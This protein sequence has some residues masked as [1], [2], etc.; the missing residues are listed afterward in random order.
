M[1]DMFH[2][3]LSVKLEVRLIDQNRSLGGATGDQQQVFCRYSRAG[4]IIRIS[5]GNQARLW[6]GCVGQ[7]FGCR[8]TKIFVCRNWNDL[9]SGRG[10]TDFVHRKGGNHNQRPVIRLQVGLA[11]QVNS[12]V[13]AVGQ[14]H[15]LRLQSKK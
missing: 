5:D 6:G 1:A 13:H 3:R 15:L 14:Q 7:H 8:K 11:D 10:R 2:K 9:R 12:L 4:R